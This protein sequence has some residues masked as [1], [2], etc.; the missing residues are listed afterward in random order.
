MVIYIDIDKNGK[1][2]ILKYEYTEESN[3]LKIPKTRFTDMGIFDSV[4][5]THNDVFYSGLYYMSFTDDARYTKLKTLLTSLV[6]TDI[7]YVVGLYAKELVKARE[8]YNTP[9]KFEVFSGEGCDIILTLMT[10]VMN[11]EA[12]EFTEIDFHAY[13]KSKMDI[14]PLMRA[15]Q[16]F[17]YKD[18]TRGTYYSYSNKESIDPESG[19]TPG[20]SKSRIILGK[21]NL[22]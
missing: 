14:H 17:Q 6:E 4:V 20:L 5:K 15:S 13:F 1:V 16:L 3:K 10:T 7:C 22:R 12:D 9:P 18:M 8:L 21:K 2:G 19:D 11:L